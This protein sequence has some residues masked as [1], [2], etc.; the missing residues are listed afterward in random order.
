MTPWLLNLGRNSRMCQNFLTVQ[1]TTAP[2]TWT[3]TV[4]S[5]PC[6]VSPSVTG[7]RSPIMLFPLDTAC[8]GRKS[9]NF[10]LPS[11]WCVAAKWSKC[12][13]TSLT[14]ATVQWNCFHT[15]KSHSQNNGMPVYGIPLH[16]KWTDTLAGIL[17]QFGAKH[18]NSYKIQ[19]HYQSLDTA[20]SKT[21]GLIKML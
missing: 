5:A 21:N 6:S 10:S 16:P 14:S 9:Q 3:S 13:S 11:P 20:M 17:C 15:W 8:G 1:P 4:S 12:R 19:Y 18:R 2:I 7:R